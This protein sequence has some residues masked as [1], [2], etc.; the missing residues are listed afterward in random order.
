MIEKMNEKIALDE[1]NETFPQSLEDLG[2]EEED[3]TGGTREG[4]ITIPFNP[5]DI[6]VD[7]SVGYLGYMI[8]RLENGEIELQPD[9]QRAADIWDNV[10]KSR[11]IES[12]LLGLPLPAF[13]FSEDPKTHNLSIIDG[14]QRIC[15]IK[16]FV[17]DK[18]KPLKLV[19]LQFLT[20][21]E[22]KTYDELERPEI[23][24]IQSLKIT[25]NT[26]RGTTPINVKYVIFQR[27]NTAGVP[28][29]PQ[30]MRHALNQGQAT[31]FIK[32]LAELESFKK[33]TCYS[34]KTKRMQDRDFANRFVAFYIGY[35]DYTGELDVFM[36]DK[37]GEL[38][39]MTPERLNNIRSAFDKSMK[40][41]Y[42]IFGNDA[43]RKRYNMEDQRK[44]I[45]KAVFDTMSV[46]IAWLND[47][48]REKLVHCK[49]EFKEQFHTLFN[50]KAF[51]EAVSVA[52][53]QKNKVTKRFTML[54]EVVNKTINL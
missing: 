20:K 40:T 5:N 11:L 10:Q 43:F 2:I 12:I 33:A 31:K 38:N 18:E 4:S 29:T 36:N 34:V 19:G 27:V 39:K 9:F 49:N 44:P 17:L 41:C 48:D 16:D 26:L 7:I 21:F 32:E 51:N 37:M 30:E 53:A 47:E 8:D 22:G 50:D 25:M 28:L 1:R 13:Y 42:D 52:T 54:R 45:S 14:L 46:N 24:R 35:K 3:L 6:D 15:A 23:R